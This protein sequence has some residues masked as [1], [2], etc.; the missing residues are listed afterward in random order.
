LLRKGLIMLKIVISGA[1]G[2]M[3]RMLIEAALNTPNIT[4]HGALDSERSAF[5]GADAGDFLGQKTG[6][7]ISN[8]VNATLAGADCLID[9]TR[10]E[11]TLDYLA[12]CTQ[13]KVNAVIGTTGFDDAGKQA[14]VQ[15][16]AHIG[17]V[18]APNMGVGVNATFKILEL[19]AQIL[20]TGFDVEIVEAHHRNKIDAPSGTALKM[21]EV[22]A[23][24]LGRDL[25]QCAIYGREGVTGVRDAQTIG[26]STIRGGD[27]I[28]DHTVMF[29]GNGER[30]EIT[31]KSSSRNTYAVGAIRAALFLANKT[32][33]EFDMQDVL[34]LSN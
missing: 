10:P 22:V 3:G 21:G 32:S 15:A 24:G 11:A 18:F 29:L 12:A 13:H 5:I 6:V 27:V 25:Q 7:L 16:A 9:F 20:N 34:G 23:Q 14:I 31:H 8:D 19:A 33:G 30:I 28:G 4:L 1:S 17:V 2:R 26:F